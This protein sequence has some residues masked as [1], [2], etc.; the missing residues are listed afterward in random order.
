MFIYRKFFLSIKYF[1]KHDSACSTSTRGFL[2]ERIRLWWVF[3]YTII[4]VIK[5]QKRGL[6][7]MLLVERQFIRFL[8]HTN[9]HANSSRDY[10]ASM[11]KTLQLVCFSFT[12]IM[13][14]YVRLSFYQ[15]Y[16]VL[17]EHLS[18][19]FS[20]IKLASLLRP[21]SSVGKAKIEDS[22]ANLSA[23]QHSPWIW[24]K[25]QSG[26]VRKLWIG[27]LR[28]EILTFCFYV[29]SIVENN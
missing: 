22:Q 2:H 3:K 1:L 29:W 12:S 21:S 18:A 26:H 23:W 14:Y 4:E 10:I 6:K 20:F 5:Q 24:D 16:K 13:V 9:N 15:K 8:F 17:A 11:L 19:R 7:N 27:F 28:F 25:S